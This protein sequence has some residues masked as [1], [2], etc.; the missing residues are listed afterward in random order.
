MV[1]ERG[2]LDLPRE[3]IDT[4]PGPP[5][6]P[7]GGTAYTYHLIKFLSLFLNFTVAILPLMMNAYLEMTAHNVRKAS[8][9]KADEDV[10]SASVVNEIERMFYELYEG[11]SR[12]HA[13]MQ[14]LTASKRPLLQFQIG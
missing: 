3:G 12:D 8:A 9:F 11:A 1:V 10:V 7:S 14:R 4:T 13:A 5:M 6:P 2:L